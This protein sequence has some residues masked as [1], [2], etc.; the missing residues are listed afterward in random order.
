MIN[1]IKKFFEKDRFA[2]SLGIKLVRVEPGYAETK[3]EIAE[4]H[5]NAINIVQGG[6]IFTL[7][8]FA[9]AAA[10]NADGKVTVGINAN[11]SYFKASKGKVLIAKAREVSG[12]KKIANYNVDVFDENND[13]TAQLSLTG[14][15]KE[16]KIDFNK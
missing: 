11:I 9:F 5:L 7:A 10:S 14:Y 16:E 1:S 12:S 4:R 8:D 3:M 6:A 2:N 15:V 13:L